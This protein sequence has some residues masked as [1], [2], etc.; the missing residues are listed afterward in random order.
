MRW[1]ILVKSALKKLPQLIEKSVLVERHP[2]RAENSHIKEIQRLYSAIDYGGK[3]SP[4]KI[5]VKAT[6]SDGN[7]AYSYEV[8]EIESPTENPSG[9][10]NQPAPESGSQSSTNPDI[11]TTARDL[12]TSESRLSVSG[13][14]ATESQNKDTTLSKSAKETEEESSSGGLR[15]H[16]PEPPVVKRGDM[17]DMILSA[18]MLTSVKPGRWRK[19][20]L[21]T[22]ATPP[23]S[24]S[25]S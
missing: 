11:S 13:N 15:L 25:V 24:T 9:N 3:I 8:I 10:S 14:G 12:R 17:L 16:I 6:F 20:T 19:S 22:C 5:T 4:V 7:K 1:L 18:L 21:H 23:S 2:D